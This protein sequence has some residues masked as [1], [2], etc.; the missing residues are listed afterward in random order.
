MHLLEMWR[1]YIF[2]NQALPCCNSIDFS[3]TKEE[4]VTKPLAQK[5]CYY[6]IINMLCAIQ[7][8]ELTYLILHSNIVIHVPALY[9]IYSDGDFPK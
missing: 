6:F 2:I 1:S 8:F 5:P 7:E 9:Y 4:L 3:N